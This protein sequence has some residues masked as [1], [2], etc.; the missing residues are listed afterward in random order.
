MAK[1]YQIT[2]KEPGSEKAQYLFFCPGCQ[3][4]HC[5]WVPG[6]TFNGD[7]EKPTVSPSI[8]VNGNRALYNPTAK[9]C[10]SFVND[11][12]IRFLDDCDHD[13]RGQTVDLPDLDNIGE[14]LYD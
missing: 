7:M 1:I 3:C 6:W 12:K 2:G 4:G 11:G 9:R 13:L 5:F 14:K 8:L 10:H